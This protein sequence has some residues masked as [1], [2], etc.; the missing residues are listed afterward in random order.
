MGRLK[1][2]QF[3][4]VIGE[5][6]VVE[7]HTDLVHLL[8]RSRFLAETR[9]KNYD[10]RNENNV[11]LA[12]TVSSKKPNGCGTTT[13]AAKHNAAIALMELRGKQNKTKCPSTDFA[14]LWRKSFDEAVGVWRCEDC[15]VLGYSCSPGHIV[16][17][18]CSTCS[19]QATAI[20][21]RKRVKHH[22]W[23]CEAHVHL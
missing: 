11:I 9:G 8:R 17:H 12:V 16:P 22:Q 21:K 7:T 23:S 15:R 10:I 18:Q 19:Q 6:T 4:L 13:R 2:S 14:H 1:L 5:D 3:F 20:R